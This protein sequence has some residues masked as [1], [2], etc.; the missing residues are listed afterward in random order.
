MEFIIPLDSPVLAIASRGATTS[1]FCLLISAL[2]CVGF[3]CLNQPTQGRSHVYHKLK[4]I[5]YAW[6]ITCLV[7]LLVLNGSGYH[8]N[9]PSGLIFSLTGKVGD[10]KSNRPY[11]LQIAYST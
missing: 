1:L 2:N 6:E 5:T 10:K 4:H 9:L 3:R 7:S 8:Y 11:Y